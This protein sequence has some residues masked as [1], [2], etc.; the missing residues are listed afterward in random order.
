MKNEEKRKLFEY[1]R[2][3]KLEETKRLAEQHA[4]L[5]QKVLEDNAK[6][7]E[8]KK[9]KFNIKKALAEER[10]REL[11]IL[12]EAELKKQME[13]DRM[14]EEARKQ[15]KANMEA[16]LK[17]KTDGYLMMMEEKDMKVVRTKQAREEQL[18]KK[19][20]LDVINRNDKWESVHRQAK[21]DDYKKQK[22]LEKIQNANER[23]EKIK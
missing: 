9:E 15:V 1:E 21:M 20:D 11:D 2:Q 12:A 16:M 7:Q 4:L 14:K 10:K 13:E 5:I 8:E 23:G 3:K 22:I 18:Q 19:H 6:L 17:E